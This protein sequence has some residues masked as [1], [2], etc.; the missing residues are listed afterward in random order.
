M[1][2]RSSK[3]TSSSTKVAAPAAKPVKTAA[4]AASPAKVAAPAVK[5]AKPKKRRPAMLSIRVHYDV[6][7]GNRITVRGDTAPYEWERGIDAQNTSE[8]IW[9][10]Q[11]ERIVAGKTFQFKPLIN[12]ATYSAGE[13]FVAAGRKSLDIYPTF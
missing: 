13:N 5:S 7:V 9:E 4:P 1:A 11:I 8:D 6:G 3:V 10:F 12:D 2:A